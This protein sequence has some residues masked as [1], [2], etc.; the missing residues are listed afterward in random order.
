MWFEYLQFNQGYTL[1]SVGRRFQ[2]ILNENPSKAIY[3]KILIKYSR[4]QEARF[5]REQPVNRNR[6]EIAHHSL[7]TTLSNDHRAVQWF[8][9]QPQFH[10]YSIGLVLRGQFYCTA[11]FC[12]EV[13][14]L[15]EIC[16]FDTEYPTRFQQFNS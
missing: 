7:H 1:L 10:N 14:M 13:N 12:N 11:V 4:N 8:L 3:R 9:N 6:H 5:N 2:F 15:Y 16:L